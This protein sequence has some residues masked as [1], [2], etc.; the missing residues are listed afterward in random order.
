MIKFI[1]TGDIHLGLKFNSASFDGDKAEDRRFELWSTFQGIVEYAIENSCDFLFIAGD[2][3]EASYFTLGQIMKVRD[4]LA[5]AKGVNVIIV[6]GNHDYLGK[7]S[8][9]KKLDWSKNVTIFS[10]NKIEYKYF[11]EDQ[12]KMFGFSWD[13]PEYR[14]NKL[15]DDLEIDS[16]M[17]NI[18][19]LHGDIGSKSSYLPIDLDDLKRLKMDYIA[20]GHIHKPHFFTDKI[21]YCGSPEP[22]DF[23]ELGQRGFIEGRI[24]GGLVTTSFIPFSKRN[25]YEIDLIIDGDMGYL[26]IVNLI[27]DIKVGS[28]GDDFYRVY[29]RGYL[30]RSIHLDDLDRD[31]KDIF[32]H[33]EIKNETRPD[34]D[35][36]LLEEE[37]RENI[38]G[39]FIK[40]MKEMDLGM[41]KN[42]DALYYGLEALLKDR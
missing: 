1:H 35:L 25:F 27:K 3:F 22:L 26:D 14:E 38:I 31:L 29:L 13:R 24:D 40:A 42:K 17:T 7:K 9:Y 5:Q 21:A 8:L 33:I 19:V 36:D 6:A 11:E 39:Q 37:N 41:E 16:G 28:I 20:L 10:S 2:L 12:V 15:L 23:G 34:Y 32:Y 30:H 4:L 18:L